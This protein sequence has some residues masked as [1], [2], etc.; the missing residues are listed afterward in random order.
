MVLLL[1]LF[2][3][4]L[5]LPL[6]YLFSNFWQIFVFEP[7]H[8]WHCCVSFLFKR[9]LF[10][11]SLFFR[12]LLLILLRSLLFFGSSYLKCATGTQSERGRGRSRESVREASEGGSEQVS[13]CLLLLPC[14]PSS[15]FSIGN[16]SRCDF[17]LLRL[18]SESESKSP[19]VPTLQVRVCMFC[20]FL[21]LAHWICHLWVYVLRVNRNL[22]GCASISMI[23][24]IA[25]MAIDKQ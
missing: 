8:T 13:D 24:H 22:L 1:S 16:F 10:T 6:L 5:L 25:S 20:L 14:A 17:D 2:L 9:F 7:T 19:R 15:Y 12:L 3:L 4:S 21:L 11:F 18:V 23:Y